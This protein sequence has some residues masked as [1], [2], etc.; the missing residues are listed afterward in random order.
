MGLV[1]QVLEA[2]RHAPSSSWP[3]GR[4]T[5]SSPRSPSRPRPTGTTSSSSPATA[6]RYQLVEDPHV[7][8]LYNRRGV[9]DYAL[10][11]EAGIIEKHRRHAGPVRRSTPRCAATPATTCRACPGVGEKTAAKLINT[12]GGLDGIFANVDEQTPEAARQPGRARGPGAQQRRADGAAS[13]RADRASTSTDAR[14]RARRSTRCSG[15]STSSSSARCA[16]ASTRRSAPAHRSRRRRRRA[17]GARG[18]GHR[19]RRRRPTAAAVLAALE[20]RST[21]PPP[22]SASPAAATLIGPGR[23][24]RRDAGRG[25]VDP[26]ADR[27]T[28]AAR[29]APRSP[30]HRAAARPRRQGA[31][32]LR[33]STHGIDDRTACS[34]TRRSPPTCIDPADTRYALATCS[35]RY[36]DVPAAAPTTPRPTGQLDF[37]GDGGDDADRAPA[38]RRWPSRHLVAPR[39]SRARRRRAWPSSTTTIENPLVGVLAKMEHV[40]IGVDVAELRRAATSGSPPSAS[41]SAPSCSRG[42]RATTF[43]VNST[44]PAAR[45]PL[46][47]ASAWRRRRRPRP[48]SRPT[49]RRWRS[50]ATQWPDSSIRCCSTARSRSCAAPTARACW[51]RSR[52]TGASTPRSTRPW[53][54]PAGSARDQPNLHNIPVRSEEGRQFRKAFVPAPGYELLVADYNQI[55]LRC[56]AHLADD[57]GLIEAFAAGAGHPQRH[58]VAGV[59]R[60]A[61]RR[62]ARAAVEGEDGL[63][64]AWPTAWRPTGSASAWA[65]RPTRP[66]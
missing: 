53:P 60:R 24:H 32:A 4:P 38:A 16:T 7:K 63:A 51:P 11:D 20:R 33:C 3:A 12:Y 26:G 41:G 25:G 8:V 44:D 54:A 37:G 48:A 66:R 9:S 35:Q 49:R 56:I 22:G 65:S 30:A 46:R 15:C 34:S 50:C 59:R 52:P 23:R 55:E 58:R 62:H 14:R 2:L 45:D 64:T 18:R 47:R 61:R 13:R 21:S 39:S 17:R 5:T 36:T 1:R 19:R 10:Y 42:R 6:T 27:S 43:N 28:D 31:D 40:G 57:P 29:A